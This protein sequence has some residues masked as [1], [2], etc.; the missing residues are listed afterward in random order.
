MNN[1]ASRPGWMYRW[2][3]IFWIFPASVVLVKIYTSVILSMSA[4]PYQEVLI[5]GIW[6]LPG[7]PDVTIFVYLGSNTDIYF[8]VYLI[9]YMMMIQT[10]FF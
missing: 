10:F 9:I 8:S 4:V 2:M 5:E 3:T 1:I 6:E 7:R